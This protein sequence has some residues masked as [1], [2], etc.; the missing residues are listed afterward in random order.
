MAKRGP[1]GKLQ[2]AP[3]GR[4]ERVWHDVTVPLDSILSRFQVSRAMLYKRFGR[5][6]F[7][8]KRTPLDN[9]ASVR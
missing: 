1:K 8:I 4:A 6:G 9:E 5:R 3:A 7:P 2:G